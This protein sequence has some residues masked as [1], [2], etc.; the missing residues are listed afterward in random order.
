MPEEKN[1]I[2]FINSD[3]KTLFF[4]PDGGRIRI[5]YPDG[6]QLEKVCRFLDEYH[7][8]VGDYCYHICEF[9]ERMEKNSARYEPLDYIREP[10]FYSKHFFAATETDRGPAYYIIDETEEHGCAFAPKG[11]SKGMKFC[12]FE[13]NRGVCRP[14]PGK[15]VQWSANL[16]DIFLFGWDFD[17][18]KLK[19][20]TER[21]KKKTAPK[22]T[23]PKR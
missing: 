7:T 4:L 21:P 18:T 17:R 14:W 16:S 11:A 8:V 13:W 9:A 23:G 3:Y 22:K 12:V 2:R 5:T 20:I 10:E 1:Y 15:V 19:A 6:K